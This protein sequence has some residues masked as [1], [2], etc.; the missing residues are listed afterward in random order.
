[1]GGIKCKRGSKIERCPIVVS[2]LLMSFLLTV[3][4]T[5]LV[6]VHLRL[7]TCALGNSCLL[8]AAV[9]VE[10]IIRSK[11]YCS[12]MLDHTSELYGTSYA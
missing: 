1:M 8:T 12:M 9:A 7:P 3:V 2:H 11:P 5:A 4:V 10:F 6:T